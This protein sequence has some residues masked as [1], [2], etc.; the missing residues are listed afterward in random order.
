MSII[1]TVV[2]WVVLCCAVAAMLGKLGGGAAGFLLAR[3]LSLPKALEIERQQL[4]RQRAVTA[5][6]ETGG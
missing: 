5:R 3:W 4:A 6:L 1:G 2:I